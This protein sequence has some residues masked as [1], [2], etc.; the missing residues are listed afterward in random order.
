MKSRFQRKNV[1]SLRYK[2]CN[3]LDVATLDEAN[4]RF[5]YDFHL[6]ITV[7]TNDCMTFP[8]NRRADKIKMTI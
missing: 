4:Y 2:N 7:C 5:R 1:R 6:Y 8:K 3:I